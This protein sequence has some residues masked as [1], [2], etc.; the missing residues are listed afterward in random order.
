VIDRIGRLAL[1]GLVAALAAC[2]AARPEDAPHGVIRFSIAN[3]PT[4]IDPLRIHRDPVSAEMEMVRLSYE[5]FVDFDELGRPFPVLLQRIP[6]RANGDLSADGRTLRYRL[7]PGV[8][9]S[10]GTPVTAA[11]V[12]FSLGVLRRTA[13][14]SSGYLR[15]DSAQAPDAHTVVLHLRSAW[16][17]AVLTFFTYGSESA[18]VAPAHPHGA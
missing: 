10:D 2:S 15:I 17:P 18:F 3:D 6:T 13:G 5:P 7:R 16:A 1:I 14:T 11:D 9:W 4:A 8:R 12:L